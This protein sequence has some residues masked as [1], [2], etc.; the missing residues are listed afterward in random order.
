MKNKKK[1]GRPSKLTP[2]LRKGFVTTIKLGNFIRTACAL[3]GINESTY[4]DWMKRGKVATRRDRY[5]IFYEE[6]TRAHA[7]AEARLVI[8]IT[9]QAEE[10]WGAAAWWLERRYPQRWAKTKTKKEKKHNVKI[11]NGTDIISV[12]FP[13]TMLKESEKRKI[14]SF[15]VKKC[16]KIKNY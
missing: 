9:S 13:V 15:E 5:K 11:D 3:W 6:V 1:G 10:H 2:E 12:N 8:N 14:K 4:Y 7:I 16:V